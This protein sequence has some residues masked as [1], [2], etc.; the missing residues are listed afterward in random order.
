LNR[1][2]AKFAKE[3]RRNRWCLEFLAR[4]AR[5]SDYIGFM[6]NSV[7]QLQEAKNRFSH[8]VDLTVKSGAQTITKHGKP[9]VVMVSVAEYE[10]IR[11][12]KRTLY[13]ALRECPEDLGAI[14]PDRNQEK[15]RTLDF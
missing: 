5:F 1:Q 14:L 2:D 4:L 6:E 11:K 13:Q 7:W 3:E 12:P 15:V 8:L 10:A 9:T